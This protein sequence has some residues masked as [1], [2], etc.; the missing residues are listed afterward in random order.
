MNYLTK[1]QILGAHDAVTEDVPVPEWGGTVRVAVM[2]GLARDAFMAMQGDGGVPLS[3]F[4]AR[5]LVCTVVDA[6]GRC[7]F[8]EA[9]VEALRGRNQE[10]IDRVVTVA[11]RLNKLGVAA[12]EEA[13]KNSGA[14]PSGDSGSSSPSISASQ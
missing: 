3:Q 5:V 7:I 11:M 12:V 1:D 8:S 6:D 2:S 10:A 14:A 13:E 9:D 4:Q